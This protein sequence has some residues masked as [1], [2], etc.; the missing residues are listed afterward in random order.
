L[1]F[2]AIMLKIVQLMDKARPHLF[3]NISTTI[4]S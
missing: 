1:S 4:S 2:Y 3:I